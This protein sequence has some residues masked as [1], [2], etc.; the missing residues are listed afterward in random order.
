MRDS[1]YFTQAYKPSEH[2]KSNVRT[3]ERDSSQRSKG[4][5]KENTAQGV[6]DPREVGAPD[7]WGLV[8][9]AVDT[10]RISFPSVAC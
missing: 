2:C 1:F 5:P 9:P 4:P 8:Y 7:F 6:V 10:P 3:E